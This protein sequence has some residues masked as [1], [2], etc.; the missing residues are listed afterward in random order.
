[1]E[2]IQRWAAS[3]VDTGPCRT[4]Q[5]LVDN[6]CLSRANRDSWTNSV[7]CREVC[8]AQQEDPDATLISSGFDWP[9]YVTLKEARAEDLLQVNPHAAITSYSEWRSK[10]SEGQYLTLL[11][12]HAFMFLEVEG[13]LAI[14]TEKYND[15]L[16]LMYGE[17]DTLCAFGRS[18]RAT[19]EPR[20]PSLQ[21]CQVDLVGQ[22]VTLQDLVDWICG[23]LAMVWRPYCLINSNCQHYARDLIQFLHDKRLAENLKSDREVVLSAVQCEGCRLK[24][25]TEKLQDDRALVLAAISSDGAALEYASRRLRCDK[26]LALAAVA[27]CGVALQF[28]SASLQGDVDVVLKAVSQDA[29]AVRFASVEMKRNRS[30]IEAAATDMSGSIDWLRVFSCSEVV[31]DRDVAETAIG[32]EWRAGTYISDGFRSDMQFMD[33]AVALNGLV[34][35]LAPEKLRRQASTVLRAVRENGLALQFADETLRADQR[36]VREAVLQNAMAL[37]FAS[38]ALRE[39]RDLVLTAVV[40]NGRA[41]QFASEGLQQD[42]TLVLTAARRFLFA[43][44]AWFFEEKAIKDNRHIAL[45]AVHIDANALPHTGRLGDKEVVQVALQQ[46]GQMLELTTEDL[47]ADR[48][49]V[50]VAVAADGTALR[51]ASS[52]LRGCCKVVAVA[53][54]QNGLALQYAEPSLRHDSELVKLAARRWWTWDWSH[55]FTA[56][57]LRNDR[58]VVLAAVSLDWRAL[59]SVGETMQED[60]EVV[61]AAVTQNLGA[62]R[63][64]AR[65]LLNRRA[66]M[67]V[68]LAC[69]GAALQ[70]ASETLRSDREVVRIAV[71]QDSGALQFAS[72]ELR[73]D[74]ELASLAAARWSPWS[75]RSFSR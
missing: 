58:D 62:M 73:R 16:E 67:L 28:C 55:L 33:R 75:F 17:L 15:K 10:F 45:A 24:H 11:F 1:M 74:S 68:V 46:H 12:Y 43:D 29:A 27:K 48:S 49:V 23:P 59:E 37:A 66:D 72:E 5:P 44:W 8:V 4:A 38:E 36:V 60:I 47:Q 13:G 40:R 70:F 2:S 39:H 65:S 18:H 35:Q 26:A 42:Q 64:V 53:V 69:R 52:S 34:L 25:A 61:A 51:F 71:S 3:V 31:E 50:L 9:L 20:K 19:G 6:A 41:L 32:L 30:V 7:F 57:V 63:F 21:H 54:Q 56:D 22:V 14:C